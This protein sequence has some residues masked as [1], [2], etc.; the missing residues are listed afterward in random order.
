MVIALTPDIESALAEEA[1]RQG[2]TPE[3]LALDYLR[4]RFVPGAT[5]PPSGCCGGGSP[6]PRGP[7]G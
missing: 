7:S 6:A 2:T 1:R 3:Q 4:E 5:P